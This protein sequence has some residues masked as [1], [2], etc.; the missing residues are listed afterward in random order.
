M[1]TARG[2]LG[3]GDLYIE[4][5]VGGVKQGREGPFEC[6]RFEIKANGELRERVSKSRNG[7]GQVVASASL[8]KPFDLSITMGEADKTGLAIALLGTAAAIT[9]AAGNLTAVDVV[10]DLDK[11]VTLTKA[12]LSGTATVTNAGATV[13][14]VE[15]TDYLLNREMGWF[16]ALS[17]GSITDGATLKLTS[18]Y[19]AISATEISG[20]TASSIRAE[21]TLDGKNLADD[22]P[23]KVTVFEG[24]VNSDAAVDFLSDQFLT[25][26]LPGRLVTPTGQTSPFKIELRDAPV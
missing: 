24:V 10:A 6:E 12:R 3:S 20:A 4:R 19:D 11:W 18:A 23:C 16:K 13:T 21:F 7:Y 14:Y 2:Y 9:Q 25:V 22:T 8:A 26:P 17:T 5:I 15:G 1:T